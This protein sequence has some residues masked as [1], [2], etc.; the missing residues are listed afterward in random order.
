MFCFY[1]FNHSAL[2]V[3]DSQK[4]I[5]GYWPAGFCSSFIAVLNHLAWCQDNNKI[6]VVNWRNAFFYQ[7]N[8]FNESKNPWEYYF[9]PISILKYESEEFINNNFYVGR[10][11]YFSGRSI[12]QA[13]RAKAH[14]LIKNFIKIKPIVQQKIDLF[15]DSFMKGKKTIGIHLRGTDKKFEEPQVPVEKIIEV[16]NSFADGNTQFFIASDDIRLFDKAK[17]MLKGNVIYTDA[18]RLSTDKYYWMKT[19]YTPKICEEVLIDVLL[20]SKCDKL[21]HT[22]SSVS[23]TV[24]F[25]NQMLDAI[26]LANK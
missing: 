20:L 8:G 15:Y 23:T 22:F 25:F 7:E 1:I 24:L 21:I 11:I 2:S 19:Y 3:Q 26:L 9:E 14:S 17:E 12:D 18:F 16:A 4:H 6:P 10:K 5:I 13:S